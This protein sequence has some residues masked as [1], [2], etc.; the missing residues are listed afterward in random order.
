MGSEVKILLKSLLQH[1]VM[2][3]YGLCEEVL[4]LVHGHPISLINQFHGMTL[5]SHFIR[6]G[7][8]LFIPSFHGMCNFLGHNNVLLSP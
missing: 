3:N 1:V 2:A 5:V 7:K 4:P 8:K 6:E